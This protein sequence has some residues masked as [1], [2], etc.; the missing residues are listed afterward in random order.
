MTDVVEM[1]VW[2]RM[3][4]YWPSTTRCWVLASVINRRYTCFRQRPAGY[5]CRSLVVSPLHYPYPYPYQPHQRT[6]NKATE[7]SRTS[8]HR[9]INQRTW[10]SVFLTTLMLVVKGKR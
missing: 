2:K 8:H 1:A 6:M 7:T 3:I 10:W 5:D 4:R 9:L